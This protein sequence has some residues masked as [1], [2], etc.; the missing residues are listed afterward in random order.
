MTLLSL[1]P[2]ILRIYDF[3]LCVQACPSWKPSSCPSG[4]LISGFAAQLSARS[5]FSPLSLWFSPF[6]SWFLELLPFGFVTFLFLES[7][8]CFQEVH[9]PTTSQESSWEVNLLRLCESQVFLLFY[10]DGLARYRIL[11]WLSLSFSQI[12]VALFIAFLYIVW[13]IW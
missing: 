11:G 1:L 5:C 13:E 4:S 8:P 10:V 12:N 2:N 3:N 9:W 7:L 6:C